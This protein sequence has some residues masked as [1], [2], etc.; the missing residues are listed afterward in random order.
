MDWS[1]DRNMDR[2][3]DKK[4]EELEIRQEISGYNSMPVIFNDFIDVPVLTDGEIEL[5]CT[6]KKPAV[7]DKG[8]VPAYEFEIRRNG[9]RVGKVNLRVGYTEGL[10]YSGHI[11]YMVDEQHRGHG[12]AEKACR[13]LAPVILAHGMKKALIT[14][15]PDN[16]ASRRT[17]EKLGARLV[18]TAPLPEW[19]DIC[20]RGER[21]VNI[22][23]WSLE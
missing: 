18:R 15:N 23:E 13:L 21:F 1:V 7:P 12:Y 2:S 6:G 22:Y 8:L 9:S 16:A 5:C 14:C 3:T 20:R 17:C 4:N 10:Y 11:G 19:H